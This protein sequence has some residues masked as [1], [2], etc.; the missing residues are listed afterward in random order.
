MNRKAI[1][2]DAS[3]VIGQT[4]LPGAR[5]DIENWI[6]F[7]KSP[8]GG[9]WD[10]A[11]VVRLHKPMSTDVTTLLETFSNRYCL[12]AFSGHGS[13]NSVVLNDYNS[14]CPISILKP[15]GSKGTMII[16]SC[17]GFE[18]AVSYG[19]LSGKSASVLAARSDRMVIANSREGRTTDF[20]AI[21]NR[22]MP[23][24]E[25]LQSAK[26]FL[27]ALEASPSAIVSMLACAAGQAAGENPKSGGFYTSA[28]LGGAYDF[29]GRSGTRP[30][31]TTREAHD[32][33]AALM[34]PQ[35]NP[36]YSPKDRAFPF[37]IK[38]YLG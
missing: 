7:L 6:R 35:Q 9:A 10:D 34:P 37:A 24:T 26:G 33:A 11:D 14:S 19:S 25:S 23:M 38:V 15:R 30:I 31:F 8:L 21:R 1:L 27:D 12:V 20:S 4:D 29:H 17:R 18:E 28:I 2:I 16:D 13:N 3:D 22:T 32:F 5:V 36:E